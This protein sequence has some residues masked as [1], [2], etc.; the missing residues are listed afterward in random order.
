ML[1][2][3]AS[4]IAVTVM[5]TAAVS[6]FDPPLPLLPR[7]STATCKAAL[8]A[9]LRTDPDVLRLSALCDTGR[10]TIAHLINRR[11]S[12]S[13][14]S[15][16]YDFSRATVNELW[17]AGLEDVRRSVANFRSM[18]ARKLGDGVQIYDLT[19]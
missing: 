11:L 1:L 5:L 4:V 2:I 19:R 14:Q 10:I 12:H 15:K 3:G 9:K 6:V 18:K 7:S 16:D 17:A 8:P 13:A